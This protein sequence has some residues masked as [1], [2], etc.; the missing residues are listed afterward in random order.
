MAASNHFRL[1]HLFFLFTL[2]IIHECHGYAI[3][4]T[5]YLTDYRTGRYGI[6]DLLSGQFTYK[7]SDDIDMDP[8][9]AGKCAHNEYA[10]LPP[11]VPP[12]VEGAPPLIRTVVDHPTLLAGWRSSN[13]N[14][15][16]SIIHQHKYQFGHN[17]H[18]DL[19]I[20]QQMAQTN[21]T[22]FFIYAI[23]EDKKKCF[24]NCIA[25]QCMNRAKNISAALGQIEWKCNQNKNQKFAINCLLGF[26]N[27]MNVLC[28]FFRAKCKCIYLS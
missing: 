28:V 4:E 15:Q 12:L 6:D 14:C 25:L 16:P 19:L 10:H 22:P 9:K 20:N 17:A 24:C 3:N 23:Q 26:R 11:P 5:V 21:K 7:M 18:N 13:C 2:I 8:C 1:E 27:C